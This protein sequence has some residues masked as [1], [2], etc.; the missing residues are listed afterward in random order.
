[1]VDD[2]ALTEFTPTQWN[3]ADDKRWFFRQFQRF[4]SSGF[5]RK[6]FTQRFYNRLSN[7]FGHIAHCDIHGFWAAHF[8]CTR[9]QLAFLQQTVQWPCWGDP[10]Y[11]YSDVESALRKWVLREGYIDAFAQ[12]LEVEIRNEELALLAVLQTKHGI[13]PA[14]PVALQPIPV[15][16][17]IV[18]A[19]PMEPLQQ[20]LGF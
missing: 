1:M 17:G 18:Q 5:A 16:R 10:T 12:R 11:T 15:K 2:Y 4:V 14:R 8:T 13:T 7:T 3:S 20:A 6:Y 19:P 9:D